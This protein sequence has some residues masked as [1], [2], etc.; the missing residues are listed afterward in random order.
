MTSSLSI[1]GTYSG[2]TMETVDQLIQAESG[3]LTQYTNQQTVLTN[4][5][6]AWKDINTRLDT[7]YKRFDTLKDNKTFDSKTVSNSN[8]EAVTVTA[9][10]TAFEGTYSVIVSKLAT[11]SQM[12]S[13]KNENTTEALSVSGDLT[14]TTANQEDYTDTKSFVIKISEEDSL[15]DIVTKINIKAKEEK[16]GLQA[17]IVDNRL[18]LTDT[19]MGARSITLTENSE[20]EGSIKSN[21]GLDNATVTYGDAAELSVN[22]IAIK[23]NTN[24]ITDVVEGLTFNLV[25]VSESN[26]VSS[27]KVT[28]DSGKTTEA[29]Q[30]FVDQYNSV[31][32]FV[33]QQLDVGDPSADGN[34]TGA[35]TGDS[36]LMRLQSQLRS[37][38]TSS[39]ND[40]TQPIKSL[41]ELGIKV[42]RYGQASLD[43]TKLKE[44][45]TENSN[46]IQEFF[47]REKPVIGTDG[48]TT[49]EKEEVGL[50]QKM[51]TFINEYIGEKTGVIT[52]KSQTLDDMIKEL[53]ERITVFNERLATKRE[54]YIAQFTALD[55]AMMEAE[56]QLSYLM[57]QVGTTTQQN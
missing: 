13:E 14:L 12:V 8:E 11:S 34:T 30:A 33:D 37:L 38:M 44:L 32:S 22:G 51:T 15:K 18:V 27:I 53:D 28:E 48:N 5:K 36:S 7:L 20:G 24:T 55:V 26:K 6:N 3:K 40:D 47:F 4:E 56:S 1:M 41:E 10:T 16:S 17:S 31:M 45:L 46:N 35:L 49:G 25:A 29:I 43:E 9:E 19:D 2:I 21:L 42:D 23:K 52:N 50:A 54:R 39:V 57:S